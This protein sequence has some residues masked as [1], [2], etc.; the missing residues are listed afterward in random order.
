[1]SKLKK[2]HENQCQQ[3]PLVTINTSIHSLPVELH[4]MRFQSQQ[5]CHNFM[6]ALHSAGNMRIPNTELLLNK[7]ELQSFSVPVLQNKPYDKN[8]SFI[9]SK[10]V[11]NWSH[12]FNGNGSINLHKRKYNI[13]IQMMKYKI[14]LVSACRPS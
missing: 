3:L 11:Q 2:N 6:N 8:H 4:V 13:S 7:L 1:M 14:T 5:K 10:S 9:Y 12:T